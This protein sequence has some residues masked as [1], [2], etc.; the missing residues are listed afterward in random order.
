M[1]KPSPICVNCEHPDTT[2]FGEP[3]APDDG[4]FFEEDEPVEEVIDA[5][6]KGEK[7]ETTYPC[8][9]NGCGCTDFVFL[10]AFALNGW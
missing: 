4:G 5:F 10:P 1:G 7:V 2:H 8:R 6:D 9:D 3:A